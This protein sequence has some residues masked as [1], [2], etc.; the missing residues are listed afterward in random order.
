[1]R[2]LN[3]NEK[4]QP[5]TID[6]MAKYLLYNAGFVDRWL[7]WIKEYDGGTL[8]ECFIHPGVDFSKVPEVCM[9]CNQP[10]GR[11]ALF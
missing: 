5:V 1:M 11:L 7:G 2:S 6:L 9:G 3:R 8:M 4:E 10:R